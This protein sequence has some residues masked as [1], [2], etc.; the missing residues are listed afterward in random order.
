MD[1]EAIRAAR[2][3]DP[4]RP[5]NL[6]LDDGRELLVDKACY[7]TISPTKRF[8][9]HSSLER[10]EHITV[11]KIRAVQFVADRPILGGEP[12][13]KAGR[14]DRRGVGAILHAACSSR[15]P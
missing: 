1:I 2:L 3:A 12:D 5:F 8:V 11:G 13:T 4:F 7:L 9:T 15:S 6:A 10:L 14:H